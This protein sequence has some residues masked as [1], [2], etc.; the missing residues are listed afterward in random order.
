MDRKIR[1]SL[2]LAF[3]LHSVL[4]A[5]NFQER[6]FDSYAH[7]FFA[8]HYRRAWFS[9]WEPRWYGGFYVSTYPPLAHQTIALLSFL[10][11]LEYSYQLLT[12]LL[13]ILL[14]LSIYNF[15]KIFVSENAA[16][17][18][19]IL[20]VLLPSV[21]TTIY[22][23]GQFTTIFSLVLLLFSL[24]YFN[25]FMKH[26]GRLNYVISLCLLVASVCSHNF[27]PFFFLPIIFATLLLKLIL[28][29]DLRAIGHLSILFIT[30]LVISTIL[31]W[32]FIEHLLK[33]ASGD[34]QKPIFHA[35]RTNLFV[36]LN[37]FVYFFLLMYG[38]III[39]L[40]M[41]TA[42]VARRREYSTLPLLIFGII[43]FLLGLGG[44]TTI[45]S[46]LFGHF[47]E[48]LTYDR[49]ALW[50][51][52][53]L[54]PLFGL[55]FEENQKNEKFFKGF[56]L[57]S[58][59]FVAIIFNVSVKGQY[60]PER[61][62]LEPIIEF[63]SKDENWKWR[64]LTLEFGAAQLSKLSMLTNATTLDGFYVHARN[65]PVL[66][67]SGIETI[68]GARYWNNGTNVLKYIL[69]HAKEYKIKFVFC[70]SPLYY[71][72]LIDSNFTILFSQDNTRDGRLGRTT[73]WAYKDEVPQLSEDEIKID[74]NE[75]DLQEVVWGLIPLVLLLAIVCSVVQHLRS[76]IRNFIK[77]HN[78]KDR[79]QN[80]SP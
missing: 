37:A 17:Y 58:I 14:P 46:L 6:T 55:V 75:I 78:I 24:H 31:L 80:N 40:P 18:S 47:W 11:G 22:I 73:I 9:L 33:I 5:S 50:S 52:I 15:S 30:A 43:S 2:F 57:L 64:Y 25:M 35:S 38:P 62:N 41:S 39:L 7:M 32:P 10:I 53:I 56:F 54:L 69:A 4:I 29:R 36:N 72:I 45:P 67:R 65:V 70:A 76:T 68:D 66:M 49:F 34:G 79:R 61:V 3:I 51:S 28:K 74:Y 16:G 27:T 42:L 1:I 19:S 60:L 77:P 12:L 59:V 20:A 23:F 48:L 26:K 13:L 71:E 21:L 8:D 63:L 44:T